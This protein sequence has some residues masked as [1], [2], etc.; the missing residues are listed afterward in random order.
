MKRYLYSPPRHRHHHKSLLLF[1]LTYKKKLF[2]YKKFLSH[3]QIP[4][5]SNNRNFLLHSRAFRVKMAT[6]TAKNM[7]TAVTTNI[8]I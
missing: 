7:L 1:Y 2:Q 4:Q 6:K 8:G 5:Q 3:H